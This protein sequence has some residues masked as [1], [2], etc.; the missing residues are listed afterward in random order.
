VILATRDRA[1]V[2]HA[3]YG[4]TMYAD[5]GTR[6]GASN[7]CFDIASLTTEITAPAARV[8]CAAGLLGRDAEA[9]SG[10]PR[11]HAHGAALP[12]LLTPPAGLDLRLSVLRAGGRSGIIA[13]VYGAVPQRAPGSFAAYTNIISLLP[14]EIVALVA[15]MPLDQAIATLVCEPL[16]LTETGF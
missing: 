8:P 14:G 13:A 5:P 6:P 15:G 1:P 12:H 7:D 9:R 3:A 10:L 16:G 4:A 11:L 2:H